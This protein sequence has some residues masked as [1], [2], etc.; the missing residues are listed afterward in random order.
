M[1]YL[2]KRTTIRQSFANPERNCESACAVYCIAAAAFPEPGV[3]V[4]SDA[5]TTSRWL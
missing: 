1:R 4:V 5:R 3:T 2:Q